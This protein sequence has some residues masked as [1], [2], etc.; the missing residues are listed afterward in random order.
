VV[1]IAVLKETAAGETRVS[2][3]PETVKKYIGLGATVA[4]EAGAGLSASISDA[5]YAAAGA[6]VETATAVLNNADIILSVQGPDPKALKGMS[7]GLRPRR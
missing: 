4:V 1:K 2:A 5:D 3:S 6:L 7:A